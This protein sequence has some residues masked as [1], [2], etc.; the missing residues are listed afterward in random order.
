M[1]DHI[2]QEDGTSKIILEEGTDHLIL[3]ESATSTDTP[4]GGGPIV[5]IGAIAAHV[6]KTQARR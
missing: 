3:E 2:L 5:N 6:Y 4:S 1:A